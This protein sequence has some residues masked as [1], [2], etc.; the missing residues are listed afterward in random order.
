MP[1]AFMPPARTYAPTIIY[2][3]DF[4]FSLFFLFSLLFAF[5]S[6][7]SFSSSLCLLFCFSLSLLRRKEAV[8][9]TTITAQVWRR[10][11]CL[12]PIAV[13]AATPRSRNHEPSENQQPKRPSIAARQRER[14]EPRN[15]EN[16]IM[17]VL[18]HEQ[19]RASDMVVTN[20]KST[21]EG[22]ACR[23]ATIF[24]RRHAVLP[25]PAFCQPSA[26]QRFASLFVCARQ[27]ELPLRRCPRLLRFPSLSLNMPEGS[28]TS[29]RS[30]CHVSDGTRCHAI[31]QPSSDREYAGARHGQK[32]RSRQSAR[33]RFA[34]AVSRCP[35]VYAK[36]PLARSPPF[37][38]FS[39]ISFQHMPDVQN[40][41]RHINSR[42]L[43]RR[44][45]QRFFRHIFVCL[46]ARHN[47]H[48]SF[49]FAHHAECRSL[50]NVTEHR[51]LNATRARAIMQ[52][53]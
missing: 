37:R 5:S 38:A 1:Y 30:I 32:N 11:S 45:R 24:V 40:A 26:L 16:A 29:V 23:D 36:M 22:K 28:H 9:S 43:R 46:Y 34:A 17:A 2:P 3:R 4:F 42:H 31:R 18:R 6:S 47:Q 48:P 51:L 8:V 14:K 20:S 25:P 33:M 41:L 10:Q 19:I 39:T 13:H 44:C 12:N 50:L 7:S 53:P 52:R 21:P 27:V 15:E 35:R 49:I